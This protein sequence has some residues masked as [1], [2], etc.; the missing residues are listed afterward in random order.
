MARKK[1]DD[2]DEMEFE[3]REAGTQPLDSVKAA[4]Q[5]KPQERHELQEKDEMTRAEQLEED[6][7]QRD[8]ASKEYEE[9]TK[10]AKE[11]EEEE[12]SKRG[13]EP[14]QPPE[15]CASFEGYG[16]FRVAQDINI[17]GQDYRKGDPVVLNWDDY[18]TL[19]GLEVYCE[20][21]EEKKVEE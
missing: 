11:K 10:E 3:E 7:R 18:Q 15:E 13:E 2:Q 20:P 1:K 17:R 21:I 4:Q 16:Q 8:E 19:R 5:G 6:Q 12:R 9:K 14:R